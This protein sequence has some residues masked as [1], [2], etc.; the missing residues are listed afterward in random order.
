LLRPQLP[1]AIPFHVELR[2]PWGLHETFAH[3]VDILL[4]V[5]GDVLLWEQ[6]ELSKTFYVACFL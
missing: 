3:H 4:T 6:R 1:S 5:L 2:E